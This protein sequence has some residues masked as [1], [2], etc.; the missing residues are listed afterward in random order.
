MQARVKE[1][2]E[3]FKPTPIVTLDLPHVVLKAKLE[4][5]NPVGSI[6]D[7]AV[8]WMLRRAI[9]RGD[10]RKDTTVVESSS[11]NFAIGLAN[12]SQHLG[13]RFIPVIDPNITPI[14]ERQLR[15]L[16]PEVV[17]VEERDET[18]GFLKTR[19]LAIKELTKRPNTFWINQYGNPD[20]V[21]AHYRLTAGEICD[22]CDHLD[23]AFIGVS[24]GGTL[25]GLSKRL[26]ERFPRIKIIAVDAEG[27][28]IFGQPPR[29]R[30]I[31]GIGSSI[32]PPLVGLAHV[33]QV[34]HVK[35]TDTVDACHAL[36]AKHGLFAGGSSGSVFRAVLDH[37]VTAGAGPK[38]VA[39][40]LCADSGEA[41]RETI[42]D[43]AWCDRIRGE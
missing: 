12:F 27:S 37:P 31:P 21:D 39:L 43:P 10:I 2:G 4:F 38:P 8:Y 3:W 33:D 7:R 14:Y 23:L 26:R 30:Y 9:E 17:K 20:A 6:K 13:L 32:V 19:L 35:E 25:A 18:G 34:V 29:K 1:I 36:L 22:Q 41:Y 42:Y 15:A 24:T 5:K 11:G 28:V 16:C 40:M